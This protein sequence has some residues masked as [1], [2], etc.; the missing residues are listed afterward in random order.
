MRFFE[1]LEYSEHRKSSLEYLRQYKDD[2][3]IYISFTDLPKIG[4]NPKTKHHSTP[5]GI[6]AFPLKKSWH[7]YKIEEEGIGGFPYA[8]ST[9][10]KLE[11]YIWIL[12]STNTI[13]L[14]KVSRELFF[15]CMKKLESWGY[16]VSYKNYEY[17][18]SLPSALLGKTLYETIKGVAK[19]HW[20]W[21]RLFRKLGIPALEDS[22]GIIHGNEPVQAVF[23]TVSA[24]DDVD[25]VKNKP[26]HV[27]TDYSLIKQAI[28]DYNETPTNQKL[29]SLNKFL[30]SPLREK[31][32]GRLYIPEEIKDEVYH[33]FTIAFVKNMDFNYLRKMVA[34]DYEYVSHYVVHNINQVP[35]DFLVYILRNA[36]TLMVSWDVMA[37]VKNPSLRIQMEAVRRNPKIVF[38]SKISRK[39]YP[40]VITQG[41]KQ[42][43]EELNK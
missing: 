10:Q 14:Q 37:N 15:N 2:E 35:E 22:R 29:D 20:H 31:L 34:K 1:L 42:F 17:F 13:N 24:F 28:D 27:K 19:N 36:P 18:N 5:V 26:T 6:Y 30:L 32:Y 9:N 7:F 25:M 40:K 4:I 38:D 21:N 43:Y 41:E 12:K 33:S 3:D 8:A 11:Q 16:D 23:F 39:L